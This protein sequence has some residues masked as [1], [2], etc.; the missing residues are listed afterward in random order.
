MNEISTAE[1]IIE[2][3]MS[4]LDYVSENEPYSYYM[5]YAEFG[6]EI[7]VNKKRVEQIKKRMSCMDD[8]EEYLKDEARY[9]DALINR[10]I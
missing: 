3:L 6:F 9:Q 7:P 8:F 2:T 4:F 10:E 5:R 1:E